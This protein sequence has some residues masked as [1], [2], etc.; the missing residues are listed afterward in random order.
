MNTGQRIN[1]I[2]SVVTKGIFVSH[3]GCVEIKFCWF[4][5]CDQRN[6]RI[7]QPQTGVVLAG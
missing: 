3:K 4:L 6:V 1:I 7:A 5:V 2:P